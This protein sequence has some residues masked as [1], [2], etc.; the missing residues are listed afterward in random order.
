MLDT[1]LTRRKFTTYFA[2]TG[3][4]A[5][6][7]PG[8][9]WTK[10]QEAESAEI[11][12]GMLVDALALAGLE[13]SE[14]ERER[15]LENLGSRL[16]EYGELRELEIPNDV[17]PPFH[18]NP[19]VPGMQVNRA[20]EPFRISSIPAL[21]RPSNLEDVAFWSVRKLSE[22][23]RTRQVTSVELTEMYQSRLKRFNPLLNCVVTFT[24]ELAAAQAAQADREIAAGRYRGPLQGIPWGAKDII[25]ARGYK[26]TWGSDA[27]K[28]QVIDMDASVI[29]MLRDA[30]A[31][32]VAKLTTG[33]LAGGDQWFGGQT[34][35]PWDP[36]TGSGGSSAGP[37]SATGAGLVGFSIGTETSGSI[38]GPS[39]RCGVTGLRPT[40]GRIS[41]HGVM[42]LS[43][44]QDRLGPMCRYAEDC[45]LVLR[46]ISRPDGRD[47]SVQDVPFNWNASLDVSRLRVGF[48]EE[49][50]DEVEDPTARR[51]N[52]QTLADLRAIGI[53]V[54]PIE[55]PRWSVS[56]TAHSVEMAVFFDHA[57]RSGRAEQIGRQS[58]VDGLRAARLIPAVEYL[59][60]QRARMM[61][62]MTLA[63]ATA[64]VDVYLVPRGNRRGG[65]GGRGGAGAGAPSQDPPPYSPSR[66]ASNMTN[67]ACHPAVAV[68]NG[69]NDNGLPASMT[70]Y[71]HPFRESE[72]LA[73]AMA[74][75]DATGHH[76]KHP[77]LEA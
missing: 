18:F 41:R 31:V 40:L 21:E 8:V 26:T 13:F 60:S 23:I 64:G 46:E 67:Y 44:T 58:R 71:A 24:D 16:S 59:Q 14:D 61:M 77:A 12:S 19:L 25:A 66:N 75:Q 39:S 35:N 74:Y 37:G 17:S 5:T 63:E 33:E 68:P 50:F 15:M 73:V 6:L 36:T 28:D 43:W 27:Y 57:L 2:G 55:I 76:L 30:G 10:M 7:L 32:L 20:Q 45:A 38:L 52:Q 69:F 4:G 47:L 54:T 34:M 56:V 29:E 65:G 42:A 48:V 3:L 72:L 70:F 22:L 11:T 1:D 9:L 62:M 49:A 51:L 53:S